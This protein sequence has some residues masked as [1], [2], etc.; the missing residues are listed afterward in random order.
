MDITRKCS[1]ADKDIIREYS[2]FLT[3]KKVIIS[4]YSARL[5][6]IPNPKDYPHWEYLVGLIVAAGGKVVQIGVEGERKIKGVDNFVVSPKWDN[7]TK[8]VAWA[9]Y[10]ISVDNFFHHLCHHHNQRC[11][12][13]F[14]QSDPKI[15]GHPE[16]INLLKGREYLRPEW[17]QF[18]SWHSSVYDKDAYV[19]PYAV[20]EAMKQFALN[21]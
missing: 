14:S 5:N 9:D 12:V 4:P 1:R 21:K 6:G 16:N 20:I 2:L 3:G 13:L 7:I 11:I 18:L 10:A 17:C 8:L 15:F 19:H